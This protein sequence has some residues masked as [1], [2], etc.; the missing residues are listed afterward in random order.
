MPGAPSRG[1]ADAGWP[2]FAEKYRPEA[3]VYDVDDMDPPPRTP[4]EEVD[5]A[6]K[7]PPWR[8][9]FSL[10]RADNLSSTSLMMVSSRRLA[11]IFMGR[12]SDFV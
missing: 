9:Y 7:R 11:F 8:R 1:Q 3:I 4:E 2:P 12:P 10:F 5:E 6:L